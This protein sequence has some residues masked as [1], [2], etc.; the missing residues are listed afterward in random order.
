VALRESFQPLRPDLDGFLFATIGAERNGIPLSMV[1]A[2][3]LL[4]LDPWEEAGRLSSLGKRE[5]VEQLARLILELPGTN[6]PLAEAREIASGLVEQLPRHDLGRPRA[7]QIQLHQLSRWLRAPTR[8]QVMMF[9]IIAAA[10]ALV[11]VLLH[12]E[13]PLGIR[14]HY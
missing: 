5:A 12:G 10:A 6:R 4:G 8:S 7:P 3:T 13:F 1:S 2:L 14:L 11:S 9:C